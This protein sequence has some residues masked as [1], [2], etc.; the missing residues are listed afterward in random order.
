MV[1]PRQ[2]A[3]RLQPGWAWAVPVVIVVLLFVYER[4][5]FV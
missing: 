1:V 4:R 3:E 2:L 5:W